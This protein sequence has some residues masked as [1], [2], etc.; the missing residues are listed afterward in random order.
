VR[1]TSRGKDGDEAALENAAAFASGV[2][3]FSTA[4]ATT[5]EVEVK[6]ICRNIS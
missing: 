6:Q 2:S 5:E 1:E 4:P 3:H